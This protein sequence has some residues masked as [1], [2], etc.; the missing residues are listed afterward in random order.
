MSYLEKLLEKRDHL[1]KYFLQLGVINGYTLY[2]HE[3]L[4]RMIQ[5]RMSD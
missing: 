2:S 4:D 3:I 1:E 5:R